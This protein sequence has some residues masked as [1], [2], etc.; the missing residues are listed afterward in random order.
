VPIHLDPSPLD[1]GPQGNTAKRKGPPLKEGFITSARNAPTSGKEVITVI[2]VFN[3][4]AYLQATLDSLALQTRKPDR[5][6]ILDD[7][8]TD[9]TYELVKHF[10]GIRCEWHPSPTN[11]GL[12]P[13]LNR[14]LEKACES[15]FFHLLLADDLVAPDFL[16]VSCRALEQTRPMSFSW[17]DIQWIDARG[18]HTRYRLRDEKRA[19]NKSNRKEFMIRESELNTVSV[20][21]VMIKTGKRHLPCSFHTD[22]PQVADCVFYGELAS[23]ANELIHIPRPLCK[24]RTHATNMTHQNMQ[25]LKAW[26]TD[27]WVAMQSVASLIPESPIYRWIRRQKL[28][29]LFAARSLVKEQWVRKEQPDYAARIRKAARVRSSFPHY[30][31]GRAA[32]RLRDLFKGSKQPLQ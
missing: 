21:S 18:N 29:C 15:D 27:E 7:A 3:G 9:K 31:A 13:N 19:S 11:L 14:A 28:K 24:I 5:V 17:S 30:Q 23:Y 12:F 8:S 26:V 32:V 4:E 2:P 16:E 6:L 22:L 1:S 20:G 10:Q 25:S